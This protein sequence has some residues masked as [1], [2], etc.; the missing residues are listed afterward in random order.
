MSEPKNEGKD[1]RPIKQILR[2]YEKYQRKRNKIAA[3]SE[4]IRNGG[5]IVAKK[6]KAIVLRELQQTV[7]CAIKLSALLYSIFLLPANAGLV[8]ELIRYGKQHAQKVKLHMHSLG[9]TPIFA[10]GTLLLL[11]ADKIN[12]DPGT[13]KTMDKASDLNSRDVL[14]QLCQAAKH[15]NINIRKSALTFMIGQEV[16][17]L[18]PLAL[19]EI[20]MMENCPW[21][22]ALLPSEFNHP[23]S[24]ISGSS[25]SNNPGE[26]FPSTM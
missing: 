11:A 14:N 1:N 20:K 3:G 24:S 13:R 15:H 16:M 26:G 8:Q 12:S 18:Q 25:L 2:D 23:I 22:I 5:T 4:E 10:F 21:T 6:K 19:A 7:E 9:A 17:Q